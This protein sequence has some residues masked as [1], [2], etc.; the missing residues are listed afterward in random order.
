M[1]SIKNQNLI[2]TQMRREQYTLPPV[3]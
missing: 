3:Q 2:K 1:K